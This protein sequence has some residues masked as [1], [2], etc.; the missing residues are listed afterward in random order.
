M[1]KGKDLQEEVEF[2]H[3]RGREDNVL[4]PRRDMRELEL[5][6]YLSGSLPPIG[7]PTYEL[8]PFSPVGVAKRD[9]VLEEVARTA[10]ASE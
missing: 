5:L 10:S 9:V 1:V 7:D 3:I 6:P 4:T 2:G 8:V